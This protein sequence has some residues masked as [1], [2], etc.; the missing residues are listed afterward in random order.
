[1]K[2]LV[3][4]LSFLTLGPHSNY[5]CMLGCYTHC[6]MGVK[7]NIVTRRKYL[8]TGRAFSNTSVDNI[9]KGIVYHSASTDV[10]H[11]LAFEDWVY[12]NLD[13][14]HSDVLLLW[15]NS[16]CVVVGRHQN[17]WAECN[18]RVVEGSKV[19]VARRRSGGGTVYHDRGN[20]NCSFFTSRERY[21]RQKNLKTIISG[22][23]RRWP[24]VD[25][26]A[27]CRDDIMLNKD[28]KISGSAS[29][30]GRD[31]A[32]H[33]CT[34]LH[35]CNKDM[36]LEVLNVKSNGI[37]HKATAS[38]PSP[39]KNL[40]DMDARVYHESLIQTIADQFYTEREP[41]GKPVIYDVDPSDAQ[42]W[43]GVHS[44]R[45]E[46]QSWKWVYGK[47]PPFSI[48]R[49]DDTLS[50]LIHVSQGNISGVIVRYVSDEI[51]INSIQQL[52]A[53]LKG[54]RFCTRTH[55]TNNAV[56]RFAKPT[57]VYSENYEVYSEL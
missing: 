5:L 31:I 43:P 38:V 2:F 22:V 33:H 11:N 49:G 48:Q 45:E 56:W 27:T 51:L 12:N 16:P 53:S 32:Y 40:G 47:T 9:I 7:A 15:C 30:L 55:T 41:L 14:T 36:L 37:T 3:K 57:K 34:L 54:S 25:L 8:T 6:R 17:P 21:N 39:V 4:L 46:L 13:L 1:M 23:K 20:L 29:R 42:I 35:S 24:L 28:F 44:Y 26:E 52:C 10:F 18:H 50:V 19:K